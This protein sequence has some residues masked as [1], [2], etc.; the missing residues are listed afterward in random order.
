MSSRATI[1]EYHPLGVTKALAVMSP[2]AFGI[3]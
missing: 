3:G 1:P 2:S